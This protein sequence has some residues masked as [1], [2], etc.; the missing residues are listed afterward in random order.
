MR[1]LWVLAIALAACGSDDQPTTP[2]TFGTMVPL[3]GDGG[4]GG[5]RFGAATAATQIEDQ[6]IHTDWYAWTQPAP[7]GLGKD[8]FVGDAVQGYTHALDDVQL[9]KGLGLDSY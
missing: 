9:V 7:T 1:V 6:N 4:K 5:F 2:I 3:V 8:T